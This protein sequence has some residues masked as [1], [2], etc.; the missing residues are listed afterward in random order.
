MSSFGRAR[1]DVRDD[2]SETWTLDASDRS[3]ADAL[4]SLQKTKQLGGFVAREGERLERVSGAVSVES[5]RAP[6]P[7]REAVAL[8][9]TFARALGELERRTNK[10]VALGPGDFVVAPTPHLR[11]D[12]LVADMVGATDAGTHGANMRFLP[13]EQVD[14]APWDDVAKRYVLG[15]VAYRSD[16]RRAPVRGGGAA[17]RPR[18]TSDAGRASVRRRRR[19]GAR[20]RRAVARPPDARAEAVRIGRAAPTR[21][22]ASARRCSARRIAARAREA[23]RPC[24]RARRGPSCSARTRPKPPSRQ[25]LV[26]AALVL[27]GALVATLG[28]F[29]RGSADAAERPTIAPVALRGT[30]AEDCAGATRARS[31]SGSAR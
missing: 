27:V 14:G 10:P 11:A 16:R 12:A 2:G 7:W 15:L 8:V 6:M 21:S 30:R 25:R 24:D 17:A 19:R 4:L 26:A 28:A 3:V 5:V 9:E 31:P 29:A 22:H 1:R 13:P 18:R 23:T 20:A